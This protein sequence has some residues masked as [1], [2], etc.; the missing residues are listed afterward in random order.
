[1][2]SA[3]DFDHMFSFPREPDVVRLPGQS[4]DLSVPQGKKVLVTDLYI[5]NLGGGFSMTLLMEAI[6]SSSFEIRYSFRTESNS[7]TIINFTTGLKFGDINPIQGRIRLQ[8]V[9]ASQASIL[10]RVCGVFID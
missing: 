10:P 7:A 4:F 6:G 2:V 9:Q 3:H 8:N 1:M 5:A